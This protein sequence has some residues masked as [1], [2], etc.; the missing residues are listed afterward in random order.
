M[1]NYSQ[2]AQKYINQLQLNGNYRCFIPLK[3]VDGVIYNYYNKNVINWCS[4]DYNRHTQNPILKNNIIQYI[5]DYGI[6]AGGTRNI[7]GTS[8][9]HVDLENRIANFHNQDSG[10]IF[11]SGFLANFSTLSSFGKLFPKATIYSDKDNHSSIIQGIKNS[12]LSKHIYHHNDLDQLQHFLKYDISQY[13]IIVV[14]SIYSM[15]GSII[16][17]EKLIYLKNKYNA[18]TYIDEIHA[19]G[20][21]GETGAGLTQLF[22]CQKDFDIIMGGFGKGI[23]TIGGYITGNQYLID[24][25]RSIASGFIFTTS[26]P[27]HLS[28]I[29]IDSINLLEENISQIQKKRNQNIRYFHQVMDKYQIPLIENNFPESHIISILIGKSILTNQIASKLLDLGHYI[30][31]I[32][33]PTV[34]I[35]TERFRISITDKHSLEMIDDLGYQLDKIINTTY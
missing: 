16:D 26:T 12:G 27:P 29:T 21:Y 13:K 11:N 19:V 9:L 31:P 7:S 1:I 33:Y 20:V 15:D 10:L 4:N 5:N 17:F 22:Q 2:I 8:P 25:I 24:A 18:L 32:N 28:K 30:Q 35:N 14:E 6:G 34:P 23:G 3:Y